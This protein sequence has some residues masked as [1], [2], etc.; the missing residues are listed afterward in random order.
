[1]MT[2]IAYKSVPFENSWNK[3][4]NLKHLRVHFDTM[5]KFM[6]FENGNFCGINLIIWRVNDYI[7]LFCGI[8]L[9]IWRVND[10]ILD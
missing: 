10:H 3:L 7:Y 8:N 1:M 4:L 6:S 9:I 2:M 5:L